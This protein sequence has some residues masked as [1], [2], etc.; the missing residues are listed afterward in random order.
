LGASERSLSTR[1]TVLLIIHACGDRVEGRTVLQ[2]LAYFASLALHTGLGHRAHYYGPFSPK[3]EDALNNAVIAGELHETVERMPDWHGGPDLLKYTYTLDHA[4]E[5]RVDSLIENHP[6]AWDRIH[7]AVTAIQDA[8]PNL[9][10]KTLSSAAKTHL[11]VS[12]AEGPVP[13]EEIPVFARRLGWHLSPT[14]VTR[15]VDILQKLQLVDVKD[16]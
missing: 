14:Q 5:R 10:Q 11:I 9:D 16:P 1:D 15:T 12:E 13:V 7:G 4:G 8:L 2:K 3:V 6:Q